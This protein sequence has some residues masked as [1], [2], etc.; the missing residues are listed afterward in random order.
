MEARNRGANPQNTERK[1][2]STQ[3]SAASEK[4]PSRKKEK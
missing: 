1:K 4:Y 3:N 2:L